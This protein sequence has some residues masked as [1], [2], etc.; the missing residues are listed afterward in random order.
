MIRG[1]AVIFGGTSATTNQEITRTNADANSVLS[2]G[3]KETL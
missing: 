3:A 1:K 2:L